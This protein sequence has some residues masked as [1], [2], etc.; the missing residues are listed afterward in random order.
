MILSHRAKAIILSLL[1]TLILLGGEGISLLP[2]SGPVN[3]GIE[4]GSLLSRPSAS[5]RYQYAAHVFRSSHPFKKGSAIDRGSRSQSDVVAGPA[6]AATFEVSF[7]ADLLSHDPEWLGVERRSG[8]R[9]RAKG[10][11]PPL[12]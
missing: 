2:I 4:V 1:L 10:R 7:S 8:I 6:N 3:P 9:D 11:S 12:C 5:N